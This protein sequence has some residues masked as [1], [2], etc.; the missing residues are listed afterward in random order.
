MMFRL[1]NTAI[2]FSVLGVLMWSSMHLAAVRN[3]HGSGLCSHGVGLRGIHRSFSSR[4]PTVDSPLPCI[5]GMTIDAMATHSINSTRASSSVNTRGSGVSIFPRANRVCIDYGPRLIGVARSDY[6]TDVVQ[7][8]G[9]IVNDGNLTDVSYKILKLARQF[10]ASE[11]V[12]GVPLDSDGVMSRSVRN[13]NGQLCLNFSNVFSS[14]A[15]HSYNNSS[16]R[17]V[18]FDERYS[19][20]EARWRIQTDKIKGDYSSVLTYILYRCWM[21]ACMS[22]NTSPLMHIPSLSGCDVCGMHPGAVH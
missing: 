5:T 6:F 11:A 2:G 14:I 17:T 22:C 20:R 7:P 16:F 3:L 12:I 13:I 9:T 8:Y 4:C 18:L 10:S 21:S 15:A 1:M 19:T